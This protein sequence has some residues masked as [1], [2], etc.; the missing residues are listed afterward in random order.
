VKVIGVTGWTVL[1]ALLCL[2]TGLTCLALATAGVGDR[3]AQ[4][5]HAVMGG[6]MAGMLSPWGDPLPVWLGA[7]GFAVLGAW[8]AATVL[9]GV[10]DD[11]S[12]V[13]LAISSAAMVLMYLTHHHAAAAGAP[14]SGPHAG[15]AMSGGPTDLLV[16]PLALLLAGYFVW[17]T[18]SCVDRVRSARAAPC[19]TPRTTTTR[20]RVRAEPV[21]H[22]MM[23]ALMAAMFLGAV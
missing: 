15:H 17:H 23:S 5:T 7:G 19:D 21:L 20:S 22:G 16:L 14:A 18:W 2:G 8:F 10:R 13:H 12:A 4:L 9:R 6:A 1:A 3:T 11:G